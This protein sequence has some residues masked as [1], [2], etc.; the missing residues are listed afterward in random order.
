MPTIEILAIVGAVIA[1]VVSLG[2]WIARLNRRRLG[3]D[4]SI[5][6]ECSVCARSFRFFRAQLKP[7]TP[8]EKGMAVSNDPMHYGQPLA[9]IPCPHCNSVQIF[10]AKGNQVVW[11]GA[12]MYSP[13]GSGVRCLECQR[14]LAPAPWPSGKYDGKFDDAPGID[15]DTGV[16]CSRCNATLCFECIY[17]F[18]H[19][20][21]EDGSYRCLRCSRTSV[22]RF[23]HRDATQPSTG[24]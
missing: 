22:N 4:V 2:Y 23:L 1:G 13:Q 19:S 11:I 3:V 21:G 15:P 20:R 5:D 12:D 16:V 8:A 14:V 24:T 17:R 7:L 9:S 18:K 6:H 10:R